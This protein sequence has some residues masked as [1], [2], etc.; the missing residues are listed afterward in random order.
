MEF[1]CIR[2]NQSSLRMSFGA[3]YGASDVTGVVLLEHL[4]KQRR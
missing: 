1:G 2:T 3:A 4:T